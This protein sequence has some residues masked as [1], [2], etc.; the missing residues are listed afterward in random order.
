MKGYE[1]SELTVMEDGQTAAQLV[2]TRKSEV[3]CLVVDLIETNGKLNFV[4]NA[5]F[6]I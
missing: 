6:Q 3:S 5:N 1:K 2:D 4:K